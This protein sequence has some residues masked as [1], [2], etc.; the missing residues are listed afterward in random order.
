MA[1]R[2]CILDGFSKTYA[3]TGWRL[4]FGVMPLWLAPQISR[5]VTN[6]NSCTATATQLAGREA[7]TGPQDSVVAMVQEF[8][9]R[10][11]LVVERLNGIEG[12][13]CTMPDGAFYAFPNIR[14]TG[15]KSRELADFL[16]YEA[17]VAV[18][19][20]TAFGDNG[21]G[22]LRLSYANSYENL[23]KALD[24]MKQLL[25]T[26]RPVATS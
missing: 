13:S 12:V 23:K 19:S 5:L 1:E 15:M 21:E 4:G 2:T 10:R 22:Y 17:G 26:R 16:L 6:C 14:G 11:D 8:R 18:L 20:G 3:M 25:E 7:L 9:R 24:R